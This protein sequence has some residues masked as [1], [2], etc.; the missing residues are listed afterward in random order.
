LSG[1][2]PTLVVVD[3]GVLVCRLVEGDES[4][5]AAHVMIDFC[6]NLKLAAQQTLPYVHIFLLN[7][8]GGWKKSSKE[9]ALKK[10]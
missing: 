5:N 8:A 7:Q 10:A 3:L 4:A 2:K 1:S 6:Q 9:S